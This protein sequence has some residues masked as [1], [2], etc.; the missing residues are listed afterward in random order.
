MKSTRRESRGKGLGSRATM[1]GEM[2]T[3]TA[4]TVPLRQCGQRNQ[5]KAK[6]R[7]GPPAPHDHIIARI[8]TRILTQIAQ[9]ADPTLFSLFLALL[10]LFA[11]SFYLGFSRCFRGFGR[12]RSLF[13]CWSLA[14][15]CRSSRLRGRFW[16][17]RNRR[18]C[19]SLACWRG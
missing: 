12:L 11:G 16:F 9:T 18:F 2:S 6:R 14:G 13:H 1:R 5:D 7:D 15:R 19:S 4:P 10:L 3:P 17:L 8:P